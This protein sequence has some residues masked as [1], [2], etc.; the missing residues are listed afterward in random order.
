MDVPN[1][2]GADGAALWT[3][4][5]AEIELNPSELEQLR[6]AC[7]AADMVAELTAA[8]VGEPM[9]ARGSMGQ[10]ITHPLIQERRMWDAQLGTLL[11]GLKIPDKPDSEIDLARKRNRSEQNRA[12]VSVRYK[13]GGI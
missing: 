3:S 11:R 7:R 12:N 2:L 4:V 5:T 1:D 10:L 6:A 9:T 8:L 13:R